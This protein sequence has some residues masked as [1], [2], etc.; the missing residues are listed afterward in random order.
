MSIRI[1]AVGDISFNGCYQDLVAQGRQNTVF[2]NIRAGFNG[3][4]VIGN[5]ESPLTA[6]A[7]VFPRCRHRLRGHPARA[8]RESGF[9]AL[10]RG[11]NHAMDF[12]WD[13][14]L[15]TIELLRAEGIPF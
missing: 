8:L 7:E 2:S 13:A 14:L 1:N 15:E 6:R 5:L 12:G 3:D 10:S 9:N 4:L 11:N